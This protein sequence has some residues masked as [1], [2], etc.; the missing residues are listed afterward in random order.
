MLK[1]RNIRETAIQFLYFNDLQGGSKTDQI[2]D[3]FWEI[4]QETSLKKINYARAK[5]MLHVAQGRDSKVAKLVEQAPTVLAQLKA[6]PDTESLISALKKVVST[7]KLLSGCVDDL[8]T[9]LKTKGIEELSLDAID[10]LIEAN[11]PIA[12]SHQRWS[13]TRLSFPKLTNSLESITASVS[14]LAKVSA[15]LDA[16]EDPD[17]AITDFAH[18]RASNS[19]ITISRQAVKDLVDNVFENQ[20]SIDALLADTIENYQPE[21]VDLVDRAILRLAVYE[22]NY[23]EDIPRSVCINEAIEIAKRFSTTESSR[24]INGVLDSI[25]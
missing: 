17:S 19:E 10:N 12:E 20:E 5:A 13:E 23:C 21:R 22:M 15:R 11:K 7:Q 2:E 6:T 14:H 8:K 3:T 24:F 18:L 1:R 4:T 16:I 9:S 25:K